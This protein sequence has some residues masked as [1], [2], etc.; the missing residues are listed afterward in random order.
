MV[1]VVF[2]L[3]VLVFLVVDELFENFA[4]NHMSG[5]NIRI[6]PYWYDMWQVIFPNIIVTVEVFSLGNSIGACAY[7]VELY[8]DL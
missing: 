1:L 2:F 7:L 3:V 8:L 5:G 4:Y 6:V